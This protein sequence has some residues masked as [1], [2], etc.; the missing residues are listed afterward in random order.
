[1]PNVPHSTRLDKEISERYK[2]L[3]KAEKRSVAQLLAISAEA[4]LSV[5]EAAH[6]NSL[7]ALSEAPAK[8]RGKKT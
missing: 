1:M 3:A 8:T 7:I 6:A 2:R 5:L 4:H